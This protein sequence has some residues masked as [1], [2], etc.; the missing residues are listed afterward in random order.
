MILQRVD[1][2]PSTWP[3]PTDP[4]EGKIQKPV[5]SSRDENLQETISDAQAESGIYSG[6][7]IMQQSVHPQQQQQPTSSHESIQQE[8]PDTDSAQAES[9][10]SVSYSGNGCVIVSK[11]A[12]N[13]HLT[14]SWPQHSQADIPFETELKVIFNCLTSL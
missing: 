9:K 5:V 2:P 7:N 4:F 6:E 8:T 11:I 13:K 10:L 12:S 1:L 3:T 14:R